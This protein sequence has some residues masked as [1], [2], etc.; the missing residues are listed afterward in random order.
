MSEV[1]T[2]LIMG[3]ISVTGRQIETSDRIP[4]PQKQVCYPHMRS[5]FQ[6]K[7]IGAIITFRVGRIQR[8]V[9]PFYS[10]IDSL[11]K[12]PAASL[13]CDKQMFTG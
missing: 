9:F 11:M 2:N 1:D 7:F 10:Y 12:R 4:S 5:Q 8:H 13:Q 3:D 6:A